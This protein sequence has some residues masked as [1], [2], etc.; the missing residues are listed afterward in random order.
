[1]KVEGGYC[2]EGLITLLRLEEYIPYMGERVILYLLFETGYEVSAAQVAGWELA[3]RMEREK[4]G[5]LAA[6]ERAMEGE[7]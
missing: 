5:A 1:M 3:R 2:I 6:I 7:S 4:G